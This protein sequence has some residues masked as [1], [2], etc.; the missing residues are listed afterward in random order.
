[1]SENVDENGSKSP[2]LD[3]Y[4]KCQIWQ[5]YKIGGKLAVKKPSYT[6]NVVTTKGWHQKNLHALNSLPGLPTNNTHP[7][8]FSNSKIA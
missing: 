5:F 2:I 3:A 8:S 1:M 6:Q 7:I 4:I